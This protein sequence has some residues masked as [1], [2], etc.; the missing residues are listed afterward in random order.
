MQ[1]DPPR[2]KDVSTVVYDTETTGLDWK[3][4]KVCGYVITLGPREDDTFYFPVRHGQGDNCDAG[5]VE[6]W[7]QTEIAARDDIR[8]VG[9]HLKFDLHFSANHNIEF[10]GPVECTMVNAC[11][12]NEYMPSF[13]LD[14]VSKYHGVQV[15]KGEA[16]YQHLAEEFGGEANR[17]QMGNY[18][19]LDAQ[20]PLA[21]EYAKGD[22]T[23]TW[24]VWEEQQR[25]IDED[26]LRT[27]HDLECRV[28]RTLFRMERRGVRVDEQRL[29]QVRQ[30]VESEIERV[31]K[32]LPDGFNPR[33]SIQM[34][35][36][37]ADC[38]DEWNLTPKGNPSFTEDWLKE[39]E[40][41]RDIITLRKFTNLVNSFLGPLAEKHIHNG[42]VHTNFNQLRGEAFNFEDKGSLA[43]LS[44]SQPNMQQVPK[45]NKELAVLFR[46]VF[47]PDEGERWLSMDYSQ[48]EYR[49][50]SY[51]TKSRKLIGGY[52]SDP[53]IDMHGTVAQMMNVDRDTTAKRMNMG[54]INWIGVAK[55]AASL[56]CTEK[57]AKLYKRQYFHQFPE[58]KL[59]LDKAKSICESRHPVPYAKTILGR[60]QRFPGKEKRFTYRSSSRYVQGTC[61]DMCKLKMVECD[62][63]G[64]TPLLQIH[65]SLDFSI[66]IAEIKEAK[67]KI[68]E[69]MMAFGPGD[70]IDL[71]LKV[72]T[73][74]MAVD[75]GEGASWK[76][77]TFG[78]DE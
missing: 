9:H 24:Q 18:W 56:G 45:H 11:L 63:M 46:S 39:R 49:I 40:K 14:G 62:D 70:V 28:L 43:R 10:K 61:A 71:T 72:G 32:S 50:F 29:G 53:P 33:S 74:P 58:V 15:K 77:A 31:S 22:G 23:S 4:K 60:K 48:Q 17:R 64:Y 65:D 27:V 59:F 34:Q 75:I 73:V 67:A 19:K 78:A 44:S 76:E 5:Q 6:K 30:H 55:L 54:L 25:L 57:Q 69:R 1:F 35:E 26:D 8:I 38:K 51:Y 3:T 13:S 42:R 21:H 7:I 20:D 36:Y 16:L 52:L 66:P 41:G 37:F 2:L 68:E 47:V 12:I